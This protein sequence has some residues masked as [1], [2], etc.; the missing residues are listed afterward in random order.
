VL[1]NVNWT[2]TRQA[3]SGWVSPTLLW[4]TSSSITLDIS[5]YSLIIWV[6]IGSDWQWNKQRPA[7]LPTIWMNLSTSNTNVYILS[8][9]YFYYS[10]TTL[11]N[12]TFTKYWSAAQQ[13]KIYWL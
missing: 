2:P 1:T 9:N 10:W 13:L 12:I 7:I 3:P 5:K 8:D 4:E 11:S 6:L